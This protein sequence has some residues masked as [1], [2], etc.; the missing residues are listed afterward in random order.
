MKISVWDTYV[1]RDDGAMM[2]FDIL[3]PSNME[4]Y[5]KIQ[6]FAEEYLGSKS[7]S[8][9]DFSTAKCNFCHQEI[10]NS[11]VE[12]HILDKGYSIIEMENCD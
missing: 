7:F 2:H 4:D 9:H 11:E 3:V 1:S 8:T 12:H 6:Q 5:E 10:A